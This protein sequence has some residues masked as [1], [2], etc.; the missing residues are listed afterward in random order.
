MYYVAVW[1]R[2]DQPF[3]FYSNAKLGQIKGISAEPG[4]PEEVISPITGLLRPVAVDYDAKLGH[5][6]YSDALRHKI[7]RRKV[8]DTGPGKIDFIT[9]GAFT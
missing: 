5:I 2:D 8:N 9:E 4:N 3:L 6:Y 1:Q 7:G